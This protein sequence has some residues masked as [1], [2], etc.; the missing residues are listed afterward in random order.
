MSLL[1]QDRPAGKGERL[2]WRVREKEQ[3][4]VVEAASSI[5]VL[6]TELLLAD[7]QRALV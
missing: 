1:S 5:G 3:S 7:S 2:G 6:R 4:E